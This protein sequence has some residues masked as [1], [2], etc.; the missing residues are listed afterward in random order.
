MKQSP[1][2]ASSSRSPTS[3]ATSMRGAGSS[4]AAASSRAMS[5]IDTAS[6]SSARRT[7]TSTGCIA[8]WLA[9]RAAALAV[10]ELGRALLDEGRHAFL[11]IREREG[12]VENAALESHA[13]GQGSLESAVHAL[14]RHH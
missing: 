5:R 2:R 12:G 1:Q 10:L 9:F 4:T 8:I 3:R 14:F 13:F 7:T 11:A 6:F